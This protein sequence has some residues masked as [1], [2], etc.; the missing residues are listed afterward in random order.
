MDNYGY[1]D[2]KYYFMSTRRSMTAD[3]LRQK[4]KEHSQQD[5]KPIEDQN[6]AEQPKS[7][8]PE[9]TY[10]HYKQDIGKKREGL[11]DATSVKSMEEQV[12]HDVIDLPSRGHFYGGKSQIKV[13]Y[14]TAYDE[15][16]LTS[17][18]LV[19]KGD[20]LNTLL[21]R[22]ILDRD[23]G[24]SGLI[25]GDWNAVLFFLRSTGYGSEYAINLTDPQTQKVFSHTIDL[26]NL[27]EKELQVEPDER[28]EFAY[29]LPITKKEVK[30]RFLTVGEDQQIS[31]EDRERQQQKGDGISELFTMR[32][33][34]QVMEIDANRDGSYITQMIHSLP[35]KDASS[36][37]SYISKI[38]P[39][40]DLNI[41]VNAPSGS[42]VTTQLPI[43][44]NF[45]WP[46]F[47]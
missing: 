5:D 7:D 27:P 24:P 28:G 44:A 9:D 30:F 11:D 6:M 47:E 2:Y 16:I 22:K 21:E 13:G 14:L 32:L 18:N 35:A 26:Q 33:T 17:P 42:V 4:Q 43:Q 1:I 23:I 36:L 45:F 46:E 15:N 34:R 29:T 38:E 40:I 10:R 31:E 25:N 8:N 37:R 20:V 41:R 39:G 12:P 19:E 3:E